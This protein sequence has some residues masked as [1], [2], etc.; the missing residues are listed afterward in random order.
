M[1]YIIL[2]FL[3]HFPPFFTSTILGDVDVFNFTDLL[4]AVMVSPRDR[5]TATSLVETSPKRDKVVINYMHGHL[6]DL[7][8]QTPEFSRGRN[9]LI[10]I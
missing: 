8:F 9:L 5:N 10:L 6:E 1:Y 2:Q 7:L 3:K 4:L